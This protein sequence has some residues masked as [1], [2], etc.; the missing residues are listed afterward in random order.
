M[1]ALHFRTRAAKARIMAKNG[2]DVQ[3]SRML[4]DLA[5]ELDAEADLMEAEAMTQAIPG[6]TKPSVDPLSSQAA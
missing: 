3:L 1:D 4:L 6:E 5:D 2:D